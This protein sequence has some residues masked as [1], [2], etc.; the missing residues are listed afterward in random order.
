MLFG[1]LRVFS[2]C[3]CAV[4]FVVFFPL[5]FSPPNGFVLFRPFDI[6]ITCLKRLHAN[7]FRSDFFPPPRLNFLFDFL[8]LNFF[9]GS[10][11]QF[12]ETR[13]FRTTLKMKK[14]RWMNNFI[15]FQIQVGKRNNLCQFGVHQYMCVCA[16]VCVSVHGEK[17]CV[18][19]STQ[20]DQPV[21]VVYISFHYSI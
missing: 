17:F 19:P 3:V 20:T 13:S 18:R 11:F 5:I 8:F 10:N 16:C 12:N 6:F 4:G 2:L 7:I 1:I 21:L 14:R 9:F 15:R